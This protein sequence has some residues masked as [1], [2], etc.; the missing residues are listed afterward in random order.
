M[1]SYDGHKLMI[2]TV[3]AGVIIL[4]ST[5]CCP[6]RV[7]Q[8]PCTGIIIKPWKLRPSSGK[9]SIGYISMLCLHSKVRRNF[10]CVMDPQ[11]PTWARAQ[12]AHEFNGAM[13]HGPMGPMGQGPGPWRQWGPNGPGPMDR[14]WAL[15]SGV[16]TLIEQR[17]L[18]KR[19]ILCAFDKSTK[20]AASVRSSRVPPPKPGPKRDPLN[21]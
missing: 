2:I 9:T 6:S 18:K 1:S 14:S 20:C 13:G 8:I 15:P 5:A 7:S 3:M 4:V 21:F 11:K 16:K 17:P 12:W 19:R 10:Q